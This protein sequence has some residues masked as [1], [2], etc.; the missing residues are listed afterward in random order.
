M[1]LPAQ[2]LK[3]AV[4]RSNKLQEYMPNQPK[5]VYDFGQYLATGLE[6]FLATPLAEKKPPLVSLDVHIAVLD[7]DKKFQDATRKWFRF[8]EISGYEY[9]R[10]IGSDQYDRIIP[11]AKAIFPKWFTEELIEYYKQFAH[12]ERK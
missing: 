3:E 11:I 1:V 7:A 6:R 10:I 8:S 12:M 2:Y 5:E 4:R 9:D